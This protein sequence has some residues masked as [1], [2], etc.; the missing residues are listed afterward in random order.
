MIVY[1]GSSVHVKD[2]EI[3]K[4]NRN[5]DFGEGF[6]IRHFELGDKLNGSG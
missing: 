2:P 1:H 4:L 6:Y 5:L 3:I